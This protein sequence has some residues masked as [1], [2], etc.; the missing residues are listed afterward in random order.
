MS[1]PGI[2]VAKMNGDPEGDSHICD[3]DREDEEV[4]RW[5]VARMVAETLRRGHGC[6]FSGAGR[7]QHSMGDPSGPVGLG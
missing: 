5:V 7:Q 3:E 4:H 6:P 2:L 1:E